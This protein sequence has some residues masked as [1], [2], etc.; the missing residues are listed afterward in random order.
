MN[1]LDD[2][3]DRKMGKRPWR[4]GV[5]AGDWLYSATNRFAGDSRAVVS[6]TVI[7]QESEK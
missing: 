3:P 6:T 1:S 5:R 2:R 4:G 7:P